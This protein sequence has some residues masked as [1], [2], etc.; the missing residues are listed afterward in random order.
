MASVL[1]GCGK[2]DELLPPC[3]KE[4]NAEFEN[5]VNPCIKAISPPEDTSTCADT[6]KKIGKCFDDG[7]QKVG[8]CAPDR[9]VWE[10]EFQLVQPIWSKVTKAKEAIGAKLKAC[11]QGAKFEK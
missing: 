11:Y 6:S 8:E 7:L 5:V 1:H 3:S 9:E 10:R 2:S 4:K